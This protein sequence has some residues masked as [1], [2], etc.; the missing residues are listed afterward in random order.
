MVPNVDAGAIFDKQFHQT[1]AA[2]IR[3]TV[4]C[5]FSVSIHSVDIGSQLHEK[6]SRRD[7]LFL[8]TGRFIAVAESADTGGSQ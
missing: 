8:R 6:L 1:S 5:C 3:R 4:N 2:L 7:C